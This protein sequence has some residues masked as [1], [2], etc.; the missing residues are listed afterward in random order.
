MCGC[1]RCADVGRR[2]AERITALGVGVSGDLG[3]LSRTDAADDLP[4]PTHVAIDTAVEALLGAISAARVGNAF[5]EDGD[6]HLH[7]PVGSVSA[8]DL[9]AEL[10]RRA[11]ARTR[12]R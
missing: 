12:R 8:R 3:V 9:A 11:R 10:A 7:R 1:L 4:A 6:K 5:L 2:F